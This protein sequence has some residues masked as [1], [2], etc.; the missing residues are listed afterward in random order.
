[1]ARAC[2]SCGK[3]LES[4]AIRCECGTE[5]PEAKDVLS[6]PDAPTCSICHGDMP[7]NDEACPKCGARGYPALRPRQSKKSKGVGEDLVKP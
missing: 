6:D 5:L 1:M 2:P 3:E 4:V 7:L